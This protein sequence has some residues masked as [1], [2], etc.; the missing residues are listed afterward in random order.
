MTIDIDL[1]LAWAGIIAFAVVMYV[2]LDGFDLGIGILFPFMRDEDERDSAMNT[3]A[4]IW[5]FNETWLVLGGVG[6]FGAFPVAYAVLLPAFYLP[7]LVMLIALVFRG[8]A[9]EFRFKVRAHRRRWSIAFAAGSLLATYA[10]GVVL[11]TFVQGLQVEGRQY[12]G[13]SLVWLTPFSLMTGWALVAGYALLGATWLVIKTEGPI[14]QWARRISVGLLAAVLVAMAAVSLWMPFI[15]P[16]IRARWFTFPNLVYLSPV[17]LLVVACAY[18]LWRT[19]R[20]D[21]EVLPFL[22]ALGLFILGYA[23][24]AISL[25]PHIVPPSLTI[26][27]AA[28]PRESQLFLIVGMAVLIPTILVYYAYTTWV[29]RGKVRDFY[30]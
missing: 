24:L 7:I 8:V 4:P 20:T 19:I 12:A 10:Q 28:S 16:V 13:P 30:H 9:F 3:V 29:F 1:T 14:H 2:V 15:S 21:R 25:W 5:D 23:G 22:F 18:G 17:P 27:D 11:G 6:L 26:W